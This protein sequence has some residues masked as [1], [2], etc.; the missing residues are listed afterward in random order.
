MGRKIFGRL[1]VW[2]NSRS[3]LKTKTKKERWNRKKGRGDR[4][5][6]IAAAVGLTN[7]KKPT[8]KEE[9]A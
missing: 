8:K 5:R 3:R 9:N 7:E 1:L 2:P 6:G 4:K